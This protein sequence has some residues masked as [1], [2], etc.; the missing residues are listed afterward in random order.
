MQ[1]TGYE[2]VSGFVTLAHDPKRIGATLAASPTG[3]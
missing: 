1:L 3:L 2:A